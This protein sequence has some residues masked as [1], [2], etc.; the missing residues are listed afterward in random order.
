M[1]KSTGREESAAE[2][3]RRHGITLEEVRLMLE[4]DILWMP[5]PLITIDS[6]GAADLMS[7]VLSLSQP[8]MLL[9][10]GLATM[11]AIRTAAIADLKAVV[12]VRGKVPDEHVLALARESKI[13]V[14][15]TPLTMFEASGIL[16]TVLS[17]RQTLPITNLPE[18]EAAD[19]RAEGQ[20]ADVLEH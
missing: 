13:P 2:E 3:T 12:F 5:E 6:V 16:F 9:L 1:V 4:A 14:M 10:T 11:Q 8:G 19:Q 7:D 18:R 20:V 15:T 17:K